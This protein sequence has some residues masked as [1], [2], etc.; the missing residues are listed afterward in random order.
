MKTK[1]ISPLL[2][3]VLLA[4]LFCLHCGAPAPLSANGAAVFELQ[5]SF[6]GKKVGDVKTSLG[7]T[8]NMV[9][10]P[11][12]FTKLVFRVL[13]G[14]EGPVIAGD[15]IRLAPSDLRFRTELI[16][17]AGEN[18]VLEVSAFENLDINADERFEEV[19]SFT[20]RKTGIT[21]PKDDTVRIPLTLFPL[22]IPN[23]RVVLDVGDGAGAIGSP[24]NP[25]TIGLANHDNLRGLQFDLVYNGSLLEAETLSGMARLARFSNIVA[26]N[27]SGPSQTQNAYRIIVIDQGPPP[28]EI[29]PSARVSVPEPIISVLFKVNP[30]AQARQDT[31]RITAATA[32]NTALRNFEVYVVDGIFAV[33]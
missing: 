11:L 15:S 29:P 27:L 19:P 8:G 24:G 10:S 13:D 22:S 12:A 21:V 6:A 2:L 7:K 26:R 30:L 20:A 31:L 17:P 25:I 33:Q 14:P 1:H 3:L 23:F 16:I 28:S 18:R 4:C 9:S 5:L 32:T